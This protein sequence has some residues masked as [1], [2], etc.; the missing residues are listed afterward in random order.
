MKIILCAGGTGGGIYPALATAQAL[1]Q[2]APDAEFVWLGGRGGMEQNLVPRAGIPIRA[3]HA[4]GVHGVGWRSAPGNAVRLILGTV[5]SWR[6]MGRFKADVVFATGGYLTVPAVMAAWLR[7]IP[8]V[9][10]V[11]DIE[12]ALAAKFAARLARLR[13][14]YLPLLARPRLWHRLFRPRH[15][16]A[17]HG[18]NGGCLLVRRRL[19]VRIRRGALVVR[20]GD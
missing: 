8:V 14:R 6:E 17:F 2:L 12:P 15:R 3:I 1:Q 7:K 11:P 10:Y 4:A 16:R 19:D 20:R 5:E 13:D 9:L 18:R